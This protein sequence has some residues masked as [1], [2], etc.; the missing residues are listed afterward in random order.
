[1]HVL[2]IFS[3]APDVWAKKKSNLR[4]TGGSR[5]VGPCVPLGPCLPGLPP[6]LPEL[7]VLNQPHNLRERGVR[8]NPARAWPFDPDT[9]G[10]ENTCILMWR[11]PISP[12][13]CQ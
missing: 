7:R 4:C 8:A 9:S 13:C 1:M 6:G 10:Q 11:I 3:T 2:H 12:C 5:L